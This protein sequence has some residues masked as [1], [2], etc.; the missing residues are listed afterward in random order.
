MIEPK[1]FIAKAKEKE[2]GVYAIVEGTT[3]NVMTDFE[4]VYYQGTDGVEAVGRPRSYTEEYPEKESLDVFF[5]EKAT[6][7]STD[8]T[9]KLYFIA[10]ADK[11]DGDAVEYIESSYHTFVDFISGTPLVYWD[12]VRQRKLLIA[13]TESVKPSTVSVLSGREYLSVSFKFTNMF[14]KSFSLSDNIFLPEVNI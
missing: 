9:L 10:P 13:L 1:V 5:P 8:F 2:N 12:N 6:L 14:G 3:K 4:G 11:K 7:K